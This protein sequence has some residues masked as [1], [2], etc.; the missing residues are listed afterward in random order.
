MSD[1]IDTAIQRLKTASDMSLKIYKQPLIVTTSGGKDSSVCVELAQ[2]AKI[3]F[4]VQHNH[5]TADA[6]ET[7]YFVR[8]EFKRLES[9]GIKCSINWPMYKGKPTSMWELI[10]I[11]GLPPTRLTRYCCDVLKEQGGRDRFIVTG[12][13]WAESK[14]RENNRFV[15]EAL[16]YKKEKSIM[17]NN[18]NDEDRRLFETCKLKSKRAVNPIIDWSDQ[19]VWNFLKD[20]KVPVN[21]LYQCGLHRVGCIGCPLAKRENREKEFLMWPKYK[22]LYIMAF[23]RMLDERRK[24]GKIQGDWRMGNTGKDVFNWFM[25]YDI[26]PGQIGFDDYLEQDDEE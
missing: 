8:D 21:P 18:D 22:E 20:R 3:P 12:V 10:Q 15:Y 4:E 14:G 5:T 24:K 11:K 2:M 23:D 26:L 1:L 7:V 17:M 9:K 13:R 25:E 19:D 6:P 16:T